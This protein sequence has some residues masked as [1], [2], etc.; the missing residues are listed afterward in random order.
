MRL[1][2]AHVILVGREATPAAEAPTW[3]EFVHMVAR[4]LSQ[5]LGRTVTPAFDHAANTRMVSVDGS[6][7]A[8]DVTLAR[9]AAGWEPTPMDEWI[10]ATIKWALVTE[11]YEL[12]AP[13]GA[14][15]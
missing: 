4:E 9:E 10:A 8:L 13:G 14:R 6:V 12:A 1:V 2:D 7:G 3:L 5:Q 15:L 11:A